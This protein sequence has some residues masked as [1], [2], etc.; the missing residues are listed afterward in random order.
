MEAV[1]GKI[2]RIKERK[3]IAKNVEIK[4]KTNTFAVTLLCYLKHINQRLIAF[5]RHFSYQTS[6]LWG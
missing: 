4:K 2:Q 5:L 1:N 3:I 6:P